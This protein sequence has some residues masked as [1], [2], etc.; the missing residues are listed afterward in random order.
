MA[1]SLD[2]SSP[3]CNKKLSMLM[4]SSP[5]LSPSSEERYWSSLRTR[6]DTL[7]E[8]RKP[9]GLIC[10]S[11]PNLNLDPQAPDAIGESEHGKHLNNDC[12]LLIRGFDSIA[13]SLSH[14]TS[15][16]DTALQGAKDLSKPSLTELMHSAQEKAGVGEEE[17][18]K[19]EEKEEENEGRKRKMKRKCNSLES[20]DD[21]GEHE[22][23]GNEQNPKSSK[24]KKARNL[25]VSM[26]SKAAS[27]AI[28]LKSIRSELCFVQ[29]RNSL[30]E[31]ENCRLRDGFG[32]GIRHEEDD[33]VRLQLEA[34]LAEKSRLANENANLRR[35][36]QCL[37][38][39]VEYHQQTS[40]DLSASF[41][42]VIHGM[43]LD[44]SSPP[45]PTAEEA[46]DHT[47]GYGDNRPQT[48]G[49][50]IFGFSTSLDECNSEEAQ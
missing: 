31:E 14:L 22:Q 27:L 41:D 44:F 17:E 13:S 3:A 23:K 28:E 33:L 18:E 48:P 40:Q 50:D 47:G 25:A 37:H 5:L 2:T 4:V 46:T 45:P 29:E 38:Q 8:N 9:N 49:T 10:C 43:C 32:K 39:L 30:L 19:E 26:A 11:C 7:L 36:N 34:L 15:T 20:S 6:V 12:L 16:L 35:E 42:K 21:Q 24:L 1:V